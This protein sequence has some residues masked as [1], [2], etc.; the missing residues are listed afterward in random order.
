MKSLLQ[1]ALLAVAVSAKAIKDQEELSFNTMETFVV[2][3]MSQCGSG[4]S[5]LN[6]SSDFLF[7]S[8]L[9]D[10]SFPLVS[11][12]TS[13]SEVYCKTRN[14]RTGIAMDLKLALDPKPI[15]P[16]FSSKLSGQLLGSG[17]L[18]ET[19]FDLFL[20]ESCGGNGYQT[21]ALAVPTPRDQIY[22][23]AYFTLTP[24][25]VMNNGNPLALE[26]RA[27]DDGEMLACCQ[28]AA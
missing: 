21:Q 4:L 19:M 27:D 9:T 7:T 8:L 5:S 10:G 6:G 1:T 15:H 25:T 23:S 12:G 26:L 24:D 20:V 2:N 14:K 17:L 3:T 16:A 11:T 13:I 28:F 18:K 22:F